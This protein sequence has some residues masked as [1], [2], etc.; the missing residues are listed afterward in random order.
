MTAAKIYSDFFSCW[1]LD[2]GDGLRYCDNERVI[3]GWVHPG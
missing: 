3:M 2:T 1:K